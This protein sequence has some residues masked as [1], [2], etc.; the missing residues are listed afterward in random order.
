[1]P[2]LHCTTNASQ[3]SLTFWTAAFPGLAHDLLEI[4]V[5]KSEVENG[6]TR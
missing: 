4:Q 6:D 1:M 5:S 3:C 2:L